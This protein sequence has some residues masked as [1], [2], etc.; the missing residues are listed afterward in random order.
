MTLKDSM[1]DAL[2]ATYR[3]RPCAVMPC[4]ICGRDVTRA[5]FG[6]VW[7]YAKPNDRLPNRSVSIPIH[8]EAT[9]LVQFPICESCA[10]ECKK[11]DLPRRKKAVMNFM[12]QIS[13]ELGRNVS[14]E[15]YCRHVHVLGMVI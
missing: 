10:P 12:N 13:E 11:C 15:G 1:R 8:G 9:L 2:L 7:Y 3:F 14:G 6:L 4:A 5:A